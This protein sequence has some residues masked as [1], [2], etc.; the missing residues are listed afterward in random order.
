MGVESHTLLDDKKRSEMFH[1]LFPADLRDNLVWLDW[2]VFLFRRFV[3]SPPE[4]AADLKR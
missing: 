4:F 2:R 3:E 1:A